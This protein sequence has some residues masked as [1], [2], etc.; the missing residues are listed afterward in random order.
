MRLFYLTMYAQGASLPRLDEKFILYCLK[1][2]GKHDS[3]R[4]KA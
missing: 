1:V 4:A 3:R 2:T